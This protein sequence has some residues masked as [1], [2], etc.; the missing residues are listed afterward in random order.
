MEE[1]DKA[2][3]WFQNGDDAA[4]T[5]ISQDIQ[6]YSRN[7][8]AKKGFSGIL[9]PSTRL[10]VVIT[11]IFVMTRFVGISPIS[12]YLIDIFQMAK[13]SMDN[14]L[15][16]ILIGITEMI[17]ALVSMLTIDSLGKTGIVDCLW[18]LRCLQPRGN[19]CQFLCH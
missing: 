12:F 8:D 18:R 13:I 14:E 3:K 19:F 5:R 11:C 7:I 16:A 10:T 6:D 17:G 4:V 2:I 1:A 15:A 9:G